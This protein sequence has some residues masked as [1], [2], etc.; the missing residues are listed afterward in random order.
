[1]EGNRCRSGDQ[2]YRLPLWTMHYFNYTNSMDF[3]Y[4]SNNGHIEWIIDV[5]IFVTNIYMSKQLLQNKESCLNMGILPRLTHEDL[6]FSIDFD[7]KT[8]L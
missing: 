8:V 6:P 7:T 5:S 4:S 2:R 1:M 3:I